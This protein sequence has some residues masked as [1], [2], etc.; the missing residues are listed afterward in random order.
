MKSFAKRL[1]D[2]MDKGRFTGADL[3][4]WFSRPYPTVRTWRLGLSEPWKPWRGDAELHL[5]I[6][7]GIVR[8]GWR[9]PGSYNAAE[10]RLYVKR[11]R[12]AWKFQLGLSETHPA[13]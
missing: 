7:E 9:V 12:D 3:A 11:L 6:L 13:K 2:C 4:I 8:D 5:V 1:Q 10:R